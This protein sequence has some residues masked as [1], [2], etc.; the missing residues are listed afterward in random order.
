MEFLELAE[1]VANRSPKAPLEEGPDS[2]YAKLVQAGESLPPG[3]TLTDDEAIASIIAILELEDEDEDEDDEEGGGKKKKKKRI[4]LHRP[5]V[6]RGKKLNKAEL[7]EDAAEGE[8]EAAEASETEA[9]GAEAAEMA[10]GAEVIGEG[11]VAAE[12]GAEAGLVELAEVAE[13]GSILETLQ[14]IFER[15]II[16]TGL[17]AARFLMRAVWGLVRWVAQE[18]VI[19]SFKYGADFVIRSLITAGI[20]AVIASGPLGWLGVIGVG[21]LAGLGYYLYQRFFSGDSVGTF[22]SS[23]DYA[24]DLTATAESNS[25]AE[26]QWQ[27]APASDIS[28]TVPVL[29]V[30]PQPA[31]APVAANP[32]PPL[33]TIPGPGKR[34][35]TPAT[36]L[37]ELI[38]RGEGDYDSVNLGAT[39]G[40]RAAHVDLLHMTVADVMAHQRNR[41]F[42]AAGRYQIIGDTL[43]SAVDTLKIDTSKLF[44][45]DMQDM[46]FDAYLTNKKRPQ[47]EAYISGQSDNKYA[48][49]LAASQEW[50]SVAAPAG[51]SLYKSKRVSDGTIS[52]YA[53]TANNKASISAQEMGDMLDKERE[54]RLHGGPES[55][56][57][58]TIPITQSVAVPTPQAQPGSAAS[59]S[60][61]R[62]DTVIVQGVNGQPMKLN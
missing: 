62:R 30:G 15:V 7:E 39:H 61:P 12:A 53:G 19:N 6:K 54:T 18:V 31:G 34:K 37:R 8:M 27:Q 40:Y 20:D 36:N 57:S 17:T 23:H 3:L 52:Y 16:R 25:A 60:V 13:G 28:A 42:N 14:W 35:R 51:A 55:R 1:L 58:T 46:I 49:V 5:K 50:A 4:K 22:D 45:T 56:A 47:I 38:S 44:D 2:P 59:S 29:G 32:P 41:D 33:Q 43:T 24:K 21:A 11:V 48:A 10:E 9:L 26:A